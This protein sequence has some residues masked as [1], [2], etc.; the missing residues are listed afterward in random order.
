MRTY[1]LAVE[2]DGTGYFG[3][4]AQPGLPTIRPEI[5]AAL[6]ALTGESIS[7]RFASRTDAGVHA[8]GQIIAFDV[9][10]AEISET[11]YTRGVTSKVDDRIV[12]RETVEV[13]AGWN[14]QRA[15]RGKRYRYTYYNAPQPPALDRNRAWWLRPALDL[16]AMNDAAQHLVG[17]HDFEAFRSSGCPSANARRRMYA[18]DVRAGEHG[19]VYLTVVGNAFCKHMVRIFAGT[20]ADVGRGRRAPQDLVEIISSRDRARAGMTAPPQGLC[21]EEVIYDER[22]PP[23]PTLLEIA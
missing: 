7:I 20:L 2:Y 13:E 18:V 12:V 15:A 10:H 19:H 5:E 3:F 21:L 17:D 16:D 22:L 8:R 1:R 11:G 14:P 4:V 6:C 9:E 23:R